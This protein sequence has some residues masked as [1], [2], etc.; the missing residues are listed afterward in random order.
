LNPEE[1]PDKLQTDAPSKEEAM[2]KVKQFGKE[3]E[4]LKKDISD[5]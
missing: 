4:Q 1:L 5:K 3:I 2:Q